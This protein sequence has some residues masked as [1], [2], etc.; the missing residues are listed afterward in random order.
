MAYG[1]THIPTD[2]IL[3]LD[4]DIR[5]LKEGFVEDLQGKLR[6]ESYGIGATGII[7]ANGINAAAGTKYLHPSC[8]L[9]NRYIAIKYLLPVNHGAPMIR[10]MQDIASKG[11]VS[12]LQHEQWV[13]DDLKHS[14][15]DKANVIKRNYIVHEWSGTVGRTGGIHL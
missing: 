4:S 14:F 15:Y 7:D 11:M 1:F 2:Q 10:A 13:E 9:I 8:A 12:I 5:I 6:P 3:L